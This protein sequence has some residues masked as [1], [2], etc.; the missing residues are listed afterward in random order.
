[1]V[2]VSAATARRYWPGEDPIGKHIRIIW[3]QHWREVVGVAGDVRQYDLAGK[4]PDYISGE[5]YMPYPQ[6]V[7]ISRQV[8]VAMTLIVGIS[9][10][11]YAA[12]AGIRRVIASINPNIPVTEVRTMDELVRAATLPSRPMMLVFGWF[13]A[14]ALILAAIGCYGLVSYTTGQRMYEMGLR[15]ALGAAKGSLFSLVLKQSLRLVT[16]GL[17]I[18]TGAALALTRMLSSFLYGVTATDPGTFLTVW[19]IL[20]GVALLAGYFPARRA[21]AADPLVALRGE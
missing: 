17:A 8:P 21:A 16:I 2:V 6:S 9:G 13:A 12:A 11:P 18:G 15:V 20:I 7:D 10:D 1:V 4:A 3:E 5:F 19:L 14:S